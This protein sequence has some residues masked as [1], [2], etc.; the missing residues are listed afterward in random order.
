MNKI[1]YIVSIVVLLGT[2]SCEKWLDVR[3][4]EEVLVDDALKDRK[5]FV[6]VL[7]GVYG[8]LASPQLYGR[9][10]EYGLMDAMAGYW[11]IPT[12]NQ[13]YELYKFDYKT[14]R[15]QD[16]LQAIWSGLYNG[17]RQCNLILDRVDEINGDPYYGLVKGE[18]LGLRAFLHLEAFKLF[19]PVV[20]V[21][22]LQTQSLPYYKAAVKVPQ[23]FL[24]SSEFLQA[25]EAD[26]QEARTYLESDPIISAGRE[27][28]GN[29]ANVQI[30]N[31]LLDRRGVRMNYY[32]VLA[33]LAR[34]S[35]WK[36]DMGEASV[37]AQDLIV[38]LGVSKAIRLM[39]NNEL[40]NNYINKDI[41]FS[42]ENIFG[43]YVNNIS[44]LSRPY[45]E[46][47]MGTNK[48]SLEPDYT[49]FLDE[50]YEYNTGSSLDLR[51]I[52]WTINT[53][54][55][56]KYIIPST[57]LNSKDDPKDHYYE[58]QL[59]NLPEMYFMVAEDYLDK[60][61]ETSIEY[62]NTVRTARKLPNLVYTGSLTKDDVKEYLIDEVRREYIGEGY[63]FT[64]LKRLYNPIYRSSGNIAPSESNFTFPIPDDEMIYNTTN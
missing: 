53:G 64:F 19:G 62:I 8:S 13:Y 50:I 44:S 32:A 36:G 6:T 55:F 7:S 31:S 34:T 14:V 59:I 27:A 54:Y 4:D 5:G 12:T 25:V 1:I 2:S 3:P 41:H 16:T 39:E 58:V 49:Y 18:A 63:L 11:K 40:E 37:R 26:L 57:V 23:K 28:D 51:L 24:S 22:G 38:K 29:G 52:L 21:K 17:I 9:N 56:G 61:L 42:K 45:F 20:K 43:L 33:L 60:N 35:Q 10:L 48:T 30:Y 46:R 15:S 47:G